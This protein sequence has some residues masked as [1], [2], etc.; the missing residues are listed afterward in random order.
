MFHCVCVRAAS[1][2]RAAG[3]L[4]YYGNLDHCISGIEISNLLKLLNAF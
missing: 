4:N 2:Y 1:S 3:D